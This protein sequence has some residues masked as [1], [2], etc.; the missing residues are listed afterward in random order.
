ML[1]YSSPSPPALSEISPVMLNSANLLGSC[2]LKSLKWPFVV[3]LVE[4]SSPDIHLELSTL[5]EEIIDRVNALSENIITS[6]LN[7]NPN[8]TIEEATKNFGIRYGFY[9]QETKEE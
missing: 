2:S 9:Q 6:L 3:G 8:V 4:S 7:I 5:D 1:K